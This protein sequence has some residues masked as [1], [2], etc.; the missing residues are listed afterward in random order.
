[1]PPD[2][3]GVLHNSTNF[4]APLSSSASR[5]PQVSEQ[6]ESTKW[7]LPILLVGF[8]GFGIWYWMKASD[9]TTEINDRTQRS[10]ATLYHTADTMQLSNDSIVP[11][12]TPTTDSLRND[13]LR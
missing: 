5:I 7:I 13:S 9:T 3:L 2:F 8:L 4:N 10:P 12:I 6:H 1:V 11:V